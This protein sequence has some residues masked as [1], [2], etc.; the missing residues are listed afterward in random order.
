MTMQDYAILLDRLAAAI[1][2]ITAS[3]SETTNPTGRSYHNRALDMIRKIARELKAVKRAELDLDQAT[4]GTE[5]EV[6][7]ETLI[8]ATLRYEMGEYFTQA[9]HLGD[10]IVIEH[11]TEEFKIFPYGSWMPIYDNMPV[12]T[13]IADRQMERL[14]QIL[15]ALNEDT[16]IELTAY[17]ITFQP[18]LRG[19]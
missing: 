7:S 9:L 13:P 15:D 14:Y 19:E 11:G 5:I 8:E 10:H 6:A 12:A 1:A 3:L 2:A 4:C 16:G 17:H 18:T